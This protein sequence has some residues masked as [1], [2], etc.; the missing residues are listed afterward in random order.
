M[1]NLTIDGKVIIFKALALSRFMHYT[2]VI[3]VPMT[4]FFPDVTY[5]SN[6]RIQQVIK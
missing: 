4:G 6:Q 3:N 5:D 2:L 1:R